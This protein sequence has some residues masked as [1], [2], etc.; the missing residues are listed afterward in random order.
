MMVNEA[1]IS[2]LP[3]KT[4]ISFKIN[5]SADNQWTF[6]RTHI[7]H[8]SYAHIHAHAHA[9][10]PWHALTGGVGTHKH[11]HLYITHSKLNN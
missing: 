10:I 9:C 7:T 8:T 1:S 3:M 5:I 11:T 2:T 6:V 4:F